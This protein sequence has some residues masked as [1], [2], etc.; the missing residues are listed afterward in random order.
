M[1]PPLQVTKSQVNVHESDRKHA[2]LRS[3]I[4]HGPIPYNERRSQREWH[5]RRGR[6]C[7]RSARGALTILALFFAGGP[8]EPNGRGAAGKASG[9][10]AVSRTRT[11]SGSG[12]L[13]SRRSSPHSAA[14]G[15]RSSW[16]PKR[17]AIPARRRSASPTR[18]ALY[19]LIAIFFSIY[20][21][22]FGINI[23]RLI[24]D[25]SRYLPGLDHVGGGC[26]WGKNRF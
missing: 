4:G 16:V 19:L 9:S 24:D 14:A 7:G 5:R 22:F 11:S 26:S 23:S 8:P 20:A 13:L 18:I 12:A 3:N 1:D 10:S 2:Q 6:T 17:L 25:I 15:R 21:C